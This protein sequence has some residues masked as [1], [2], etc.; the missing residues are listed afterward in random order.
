MKL[1]ALDTSTESCSVALALDGAITERVEHERRHGERLLFMV[2]ELLGE[3][4]MALTQLDAIAF[5]RG[6]GSFTSLRIGAGVVQGLAFGADLP[7]VPISSLAVLAQGA[8]APNVL[9]AMDARMQQ[10]YWGMYVRASDGLVALTGTESVVDPAVVPVPEGQGWVGVGSGW[11]QYAALLRQ[12]IGG[13][14]SDVRQNCYPQARNVVALATAAFSR[15][16]SV[17]PDLALPLY[18]RDDVAFKM[19]RS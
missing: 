11:D 18:I 8:E 15:G 2:Q 17:A 4:G 6:P 9:A 7:V 16:E 3:S 5:G 1:L 10:V 14:V 13:G 12:R 19:H